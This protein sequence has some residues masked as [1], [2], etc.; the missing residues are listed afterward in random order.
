VRS[1]ILQQA[2][3]DRT[4]GAGSFVGVAMSGGL[5]STSVAA[6]AQ[7]SPDANVRAYTFVFDH[8]TECDERAYS[9]AMTAELGLEVE[10]IE[11][12]RLWVLD[13]RIDAPFSPDTPFIGWRAC[14]QE[15]FRRMTAHGSKVLLLGHGGD[16]L[17]RGSSLAYAERLRHC[18]LSAIREV[19]HHAR[20]RREPLPRAFYRHFGRPHLPAGADRLLRYALRIKRKELLPPWVLPAFALRTDLAGR[21]EALRP[22]RIFAGRARQEI[23]E[24]LVGVPWYWRLVN[25]HERSAAAAG[26]E[27][28]HP[29]LDRRLFE[30]ILAIPG[31]QLFRLGC[32]KSL[33]RSSMA[34]ILPET[35]R[36]RAAKT[37]FTSFLDFALRDRAAREITEIMKV[38]RAAGMGMVDGEQLRSVF[39]GFLSGDLNSSQG[40]LWHTISLEI[41]LRRCDALPKGGSPRGKQ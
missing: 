29:F 28:R 20:S 40:A 11:A 5:D 33:L 37:R 21:N 26:I 41:W 4:R 1:A 34:G 7:R 10:P 9:R 31:E 16:D 32:P 3:T 36:C 23:Y 27:V 25:W 39:L 15:I 35:V 38:P 18:D 30:Y 22:Q 24:S 6:L 12:E 17:L 19:A 2:V 14:Y 13:S 8:L